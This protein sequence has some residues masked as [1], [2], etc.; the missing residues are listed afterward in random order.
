MLCNIRRYQYYRLINNKSKRQFCPIETFAEIAAM[1]FPVVF[2][3]IPR[4]Q[5]ARSTI[6]SGKVVPQKKKKEKPL[7]RGAGETCRKPIRAMVRFCLSFREW[8]STR[9]E[10]SGSSYAPNRMTKDGVLASLVSDGTNGPAAFR[11]IDRNG[12]NEFKCEDCRINIRTL[13][14]LLRYSDR[15]ATLSCIE[16]F[17]T[18]RQAILTSYISGNLTF[19]IN[20]ENLI[21]MSIMTLINE[22]NL[23]FHSLN[24]N[25]C[26]I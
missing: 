20:Q 26:I 6:H 16:T 2:L 10:P 9:Q 5:Y 14:S 25:Q 11:G 22:L 7:D 17:H 8:C 19:N 15:S 3:Y 12:G 4:V 13:R 18:E 21:I 23:Q 24:R 1:T